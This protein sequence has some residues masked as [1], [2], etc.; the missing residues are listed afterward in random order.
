M[1]RFLMA[2]ALAGAMI[3]CGD[4]DG[5]DDVDPGD[6]GPGEGGIR[7]DGGLDGSLDARV[8]AEAGTSPEGGAAA[9][10]NNPGAACT[11]ATASTCTGTNAVCSPT[12]GFAAAAPGGGWCTAMCTATA[13]CGA[14]GTCPVGDLLGNAATG[15]LVRAGF[16]EAGVPGPILDMAS[17]CMDKCAAAGSMSDCRAGYR[18]TT[19]ATEIP[20][21]MPAAAIA[22]SVNTPICVPVSGLNPV[23]VI[24]D[25]GAGDAGSMTVTGMDSG[26]R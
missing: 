8:D 12:I 19:L 13:Q 11:S 17:Q 4:D 3:G 7:N 6:G 16:A 1:K 15:A 14:E 20:S 22:P 5:D 24:P 10:I 2:L 23:P 9:R 25:A 26:L 18:C 21:L